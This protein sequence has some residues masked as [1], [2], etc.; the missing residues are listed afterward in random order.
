MADDT[1]VGGSVTRDGEPVARIP[2]RLLDSK[3]EFVAEV[4][5]DAAGKF[6]FFAAEG[7]WIVRTVVGAEL[8]DRRVEAAGGQVVDV[9][10]GLPPDPTDGPVTKLVG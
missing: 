5:T 7:T 2:V 10:V 8:Y 1:V 6:R 4:T 9:S 3:G